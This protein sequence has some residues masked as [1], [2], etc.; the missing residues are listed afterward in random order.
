MANE[1]IVPVASR[2]HSYGKSKTKLTTTATILV[3]WNVVTT[4][5]D[6][7]GDDKYLWKRM[8]KLQSI[9]DEARC[10]TTVNVGCSSFSFF[11]FPFDLLSVSLLS[12]HSLHC[13]LYLS[14][15]ALFL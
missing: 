11:S 13:L 2:I 14:G 15:G 7:L 1:R 10:M 8:V 5:D 6:D 4:D 3:R 12:F 9:D